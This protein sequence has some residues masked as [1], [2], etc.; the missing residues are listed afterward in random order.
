MPECAGLTPDKSGNL[1]TGGHRGTCRNHSRRHGR[2]GA[3][4]VAVRH[5]SGRLPPITSRS[6]GRP[7]GSEAGSPRLAAALVRDLVRHGGRH[8]H[9]LHL[10]LP[11]LEDGTLLCASVR[12]CPLNDIPRWRPAHLTDG[13]YD[14]RSLWLIL[15]L[16]LIAAGALVTYTSAGK[17]VGA[18]KRLQGWWPGPVSS[19][20]TQ[21]VV[22]EEPWVLLSFGG[23]L[24]GCV[25][26]LA[27]LVWLVVEL[28]TKLL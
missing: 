4:L 25:V 9:R 17:G 7:L 22:Y 3:Y 13:A 2:A 10:G 21:R 5:G 1:R 23:I 6:P 8:R 19:M 24:I 12:K 11:S 26:S 27:G 16:A 15:P 14:D 28:A 18:I 20:P